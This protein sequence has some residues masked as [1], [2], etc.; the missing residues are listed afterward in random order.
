[1]MKR[2]LLAGVL[3]MFVAGG[4]RAG[5]K[6][7][8]PSATPEASS[9]Q[10]EV[11]AEKKGNPVILMETTAGNITIELY[12][13]KAPKTVANFLK[14]VGDGFYTDTIFHRVI[15]G[16]MIQGGGF[17]A[18]MKQKDA[19]YPP[20]ALEAKNGLKNVRGAIAMARTQNPNSATSQFFINHKDN[21]NLDYPKPDGNGYAVFGKVT[22]GIETV[23]KIASVATTNNPPYQ[24]VPAEPV[25][26]KSVKVIS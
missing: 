18:D 19:T 21:P 2:I 4:A 17:T 1:M 25:L 23:D 8:K 15:A 6:E 24:N 26:I 22:E 13:E 3:S 20:I 16:F 9:K 11:K 5:D 14:Y 12:S 7:E 10:T